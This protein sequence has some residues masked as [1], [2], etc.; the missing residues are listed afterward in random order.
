MTSH[1]PFAARR[2][3]GFTLIELMIVVAIIG[4]LAAVAIP[5]YQDYV[6]KS[7]VSAA[8]EESAGARTGID[9]EVVNTPNLDAAT[10]M[11][12]TKL[13]A[14]S[15]NCTISTTAAVA[16]ATSVSCLIKGGPASVTGKKI[17]WSRASTGAWTCS[18]PGIDPKHTSASCPP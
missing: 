16:G 18:A 15:I 17:S 2:Q 9:T 7:K 3:A 13:H 5:L 1:S 10:I 4:V 14:D 12:A 8:I 6:A 11:L